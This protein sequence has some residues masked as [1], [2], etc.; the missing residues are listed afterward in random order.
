MFEIAEKLMQENRQLHSQLPA[1]TRLTGRVR[2]TDRRAR[3]DSYECTKKLDASETRLLEVT[4]NMLASSHETLKH[5]VFERLEN[6]VDNQEQGT[7]KE[8]INEHLHNSKAQSTKYEMPFCIS[9]SPIPRYCFTPTRSK[10][11][12]GNESFCNKEAEM[13]PKGPLTPLAVCPIQKPPVFDGRT[14]WDAYITQFEIAAEIN[15]WKEAEKAAFLVTSLNGQA[16]TYCLIC[17]QRVVHIFR[18]L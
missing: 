10:R 4:T 11:N 6:Y 8:V 5:E 12:E 16:T 3:V 15:D 14:P 7:Q 18:R 13:M 9:Q 2:Q 17:Q 1:I